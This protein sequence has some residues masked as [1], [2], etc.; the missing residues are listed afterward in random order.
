MKL[1]ASMKLKGIASLA[2]LLNAF[3]FAT[4]YAVSKEALGRIDPIVFTFFEMTSLVPAALCILLCSWKHITRAVIRRGVILGSTLCLALF[5]I[6]IALKYTS[7][8]STAFFPALNGFLAALIAWLFLKQPLRKATWVAG[9]FSIAGAALLIINSPMGGIRGSLIA[10]L[11]GL[12][13]TCYVFLSEQ[14]QEQEIAH[15]PL[16]GIE[17]LTMAGWACL[18]SLLFGNWQAFHPELPKDIYVIVYVAGVCTF[19]PTLITVLMQKHI[20]ALTVSFIY[21][22]EPVLGAVI[23][24]FY[25]HELLPL[26][27]YIGGS[28]VVLGAIVQSWS[29]SEQPHTAHRKVQHAISRGRSS[30]LASTGAVVYPL[31]FLFVGG[32]LLA[33]LG[34]LPPTS[35]QE[36]YGVRT[37]LLAS[38][39][40]WRETAT[41]LIV[42]QAVCWL[43]AWVSV[44][45]TGSI[46]IA[47]G[48]SVRTRPAYPVQ[49]AAHVGAMHSSHDVLLAEKSMLQQVHTV[50]STAAGNSPQQFSTGSFVAA[51]EDARITEDLPEIQLWEEYPEME[52][53]IATYEVPSVA[54]IAKQEDKASL[55][56]HR[57]MRRMRL[58]RV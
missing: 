24:N 28:L 12:F 49:Q 2:F 25:L 11:G 47:H 44:V 19:L 38:T 10:F 20:S 55:E 30:R 26:Y 9:L 3:L 8:T 16:F 21:V 39:V 42:V 53:A 52:L 31:L 4:Y 57:K 17:L 50:H 36:L 56:Q 48:L 23:A 46:G 27:G 43:V 54:P 51:Q 40:L 32:F 41:Q 13:F 34:G 29:N 6:A 18:V 15:W 35:W 5:T 14:K 37:Q 1:G 45:L 58:A 22:L 7:A 33:K